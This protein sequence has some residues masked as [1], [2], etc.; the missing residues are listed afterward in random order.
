AFFQKSWRIPKA[1]PLVA[2]K[3]ETGVWGRSPRPTIVQKS[4]LSNFFQKK[5]GR[6]KADSFADMKYQ[7]TGD[8]WSPLQKQLSDRYISFRKYVQY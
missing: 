8:Q 1:E 3:S 7:Q 2:R 5:F 4:F 6:L